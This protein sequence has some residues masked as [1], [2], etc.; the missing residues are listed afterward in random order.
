MPGPVLPLPRVAAV[1]DRQPAPARRQRCQSHADRPA[2]VCKDCK[3]APPRSIMFMAE[4]GDSLCGF[5]PTTAMVAQPIF[6]K[7]RSAVCYQ[8]NPK[9]SPIWEANIR[10]PQLR[11][12]SL[13]LRQGS[14]GK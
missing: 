14:E 8:H 10:G 1:L 3:K 4:G 6:V 9:L 7:V 13:R 11:G 5:M 12:S 2:N